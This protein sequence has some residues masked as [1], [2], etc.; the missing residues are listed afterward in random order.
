MKI[1][2]VRHG[3]PTYDLRTKVSPKALTKALKTYDLAGIDEN[4]H[5][6]KELCQ[7]IQNSSMICTSDLR[8]SIESAERLSKQTSASSSFSSPLFREVPVP[9]SIP[10]PFTLR[11]I[12][13]A[14]IGRLIWYFGYIGGV[15]SRS[16][17]HE[18]ANQAA[19]QLIQHA[20]AAGSVALI[21]HG[22]MNM[23]I[24]KNLVRHGW[25]SSKKI[26]RS[27]WSW[28]EFHN[29]ISKE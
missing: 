21:G 15:E 10:Y 25:H 12:S 17:A 8:R 16:Q 24:A 28:I 5:P 6:S 1:I 23:F 18:R 26:T 14:T 4:S 2:L 13:W 11:A 27:H 20:N 19:Q 29:E 22:I 3:K 7:L 9:H